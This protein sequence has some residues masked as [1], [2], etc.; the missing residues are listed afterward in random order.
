MSLVVARK[1]YF[2]CALSDKA[3]AKDKKFYALCQQLHL[4]YAAFPYIP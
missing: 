3:A 4:R 1:F 2:V